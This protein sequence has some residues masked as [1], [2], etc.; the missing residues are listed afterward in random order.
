MKILFVGLSS[1][2]TEGLNYQDNS[3]CKVFL[4][5]GHE[6]A[7]ISNPEAYINGVKTY[8]GE[9]ESIVEDG[10]KLIRVDYKFDRLISKKLKIYKS[11]YNY[12]NE[13]KPDIIY[14]HGTQYY[15]IYE[16][17]KYKLKNKNV[18][19]Y[20]DTHTAYKNANIN[21]W[22]SY[23][24]YNL[25]YKKLFKTIE[26]YL[27]KYF[28]VGIDEKQFSIKVYNAEE[29]KME[30]LP[31]GG[32][33]ISDKEY[34]TN[35][36]EIRQ[37]LKLKSD[38]IVIVH[39]GKLDALKN[40][41]WLINV[42]NSINTDKLK[43]IIIGNV[44]DKNKELL[45]KINNNTNK[46][47]MYLGWQSANVLLKY[48]CAADIYAQPGSASVTFNNAICCQTPIISYR[49]E[50]YSP[51]Y[52]IK[53]IYWIK[54][55]DDIKDFLLKICQDNQKLVYLKE[56]AKNNKSLLDYVTLL[57]SAIDF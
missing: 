19:L 7:Y 35:R 51:F 25:Y 55:E 33:P 20:A 16:I 17:K 14:C 24:L 29:D 41:M 38:D 21:N 30:F 23:F 28:Y 9:S 1:Y 37:K 31:L 5:E 2:Y 22:Y 34:E 27:E 12:L 54:S 13:F 18:R 40:T 57:H 48:I 52:D 11:I 43:L 3:F 50:F 10:V 45:K 8:V 15:N 32:F 56:E 4:D 53:S 39:S 36:L 42:I 44:P 46:N 47:I 49:H 6:V 26:P